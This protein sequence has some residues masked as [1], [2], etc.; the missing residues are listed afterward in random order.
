MF[1]I[2][3]R[4]VPDTSYHSHFVQKHKQVPSESDK[5]LKI[6][7]VLACNYTRLWIGQNKKYKRKMVIKFT[8][9]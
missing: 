5:T 7:G 9:E 6:E 8:G 1:E 3:V 4:R 2:F